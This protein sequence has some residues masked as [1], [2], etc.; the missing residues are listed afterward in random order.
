MVGGVAGIGL[1]YLG[2]SFLASIPIPSD[3]PVALGTKMDT[4][5]LVFSLAVSL[6]TGL[7]FGLLPSFR[8]TRGISRRK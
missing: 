5:L 8:A 1:G 4:R 2:V 7:G 6:A 3:F